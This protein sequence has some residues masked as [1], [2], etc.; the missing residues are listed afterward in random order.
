MSYWL[1]ITNLDNWEITKK[2]KILGAA[3]KYSRSL[4]RIDKGDRIIIYVKSRVKEGTTVASTLAGEYEATSSVFIDNDKMFQAPEKAPNELFSLRVRL[5]PIK[6]PERPIEFKPLVSQLDFIK[7]KKY[8]S[9][10]LYGVA[11]LNLPEKDY[12]FISSKLQY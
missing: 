6:I 7:S 12:T 10:T 5:K 8:W 3:E 4:S 11:V 2:K 1:Y 9:L